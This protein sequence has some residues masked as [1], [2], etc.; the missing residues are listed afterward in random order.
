MKPKQPIFE[1][2]NNVLAN[3]F[4]RGL[5][6]MNNGDQL[7]PEAYLGPVTA[8]A[9]RIEPGTYIFSDGMYRLIK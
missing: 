8:E 9:L 3:R 4:F 7:P 2:P 1:D 6:L 5:F